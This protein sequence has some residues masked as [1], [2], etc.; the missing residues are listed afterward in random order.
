MFQALN[1]YL[2]RY[3]FL[4]SF[5]SVALLAYF[6]ALTNVHISPLYY[7]MVFFSTLT[8]YNLYR[9]V[10]N[11]RKFS[12]KKMNFASE[13]I[14]YSTI[15]S[16]F[17]FLLIIDNFKF[18]YLIPLLMTL[19]YKYPLIGHKEL[20][21]IPLV[22]IIVVAFVWVSVALIPFIDDVYAHPAAL[23]IFFSEFFF[24]ISITIPF[25]IFDLKLDKMKTT[26]SF[27]GVKGALVLSKISLVIYFL[28]NMFQD[29]PVTLKLS[30]LIVTAITYGVL[31]NVVKIRS[32]SLQYYFVDG[33]I[34]VQSVLVCLMSNIK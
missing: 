26:A 8:L 3:N 19:I 20:R 30:H 33:L 32:R 15:I 12:F 10:P 24:F 18:L 14:L 16:F 27:F 21:R 34:I 22:K 31:Q 1:I 11:I 28:I 29:T 6:S 5:C 25:D 9:L 17:T 13:I 23:K 2:L 4:I 7:V